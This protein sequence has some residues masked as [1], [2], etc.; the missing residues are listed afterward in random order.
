ME[1]ENIFINTSDKWLISNIY[2]EFTKLNTKKTNYAI[3]NMGKG[4]EQTL[5]QGGHTEDPETYERMLS[6]TIHQRDTK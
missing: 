2:K 3:K 4:R 1:W 5:L 6:I